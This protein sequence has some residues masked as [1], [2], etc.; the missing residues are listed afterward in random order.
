MDDK[1]TK[2]SENILSQTKEQSRLKAQN[3]YG[4]GKSST[5]IEKIIRNLV[6]TV[7]QEELLKN[8][9]VI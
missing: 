4:D 8:Q 2:Y 5:K 6:I 7:D 3:P 9:K 1:I